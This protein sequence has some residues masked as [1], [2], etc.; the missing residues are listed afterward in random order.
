MPGSKSKRRLYEPINYERLET[1]LAAMLHSDTESSS[2]EETLNVSIQFI[3]NEHVQ[4]YCDI[5]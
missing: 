2:E 3:I 5:N 4:I 1:E